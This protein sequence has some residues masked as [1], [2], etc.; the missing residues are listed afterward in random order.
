[1]KQAKKE[2]TTTIKEATENCEDEATDVGQDHDDDDQP[3]NEID[4][5]Q[6]HGINMADITKLKQAGLTTVLSI[7]MW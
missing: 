3:F 7:L 6:E 5:L 2:K 1:M 4:Q